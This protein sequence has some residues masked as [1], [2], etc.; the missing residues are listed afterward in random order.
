M[1]ALLATLDVPVRQILIE[2]RIVEARDTF[3]RALGVRLGGGDLRAQQGGDGGY[4]LS[5]NNRLA[6]GTG[7]NNAVASILE[8]K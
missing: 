2:A 8:I 4:R 3:G 5:G 6:I 1:K 7:Y